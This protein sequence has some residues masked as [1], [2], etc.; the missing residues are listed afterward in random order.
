MVISS[1]AWD[2]FIPSQNKKEETFNANYKLLPLNCLM[3]LKDQRHL[4]YCLPMHMHLLSK[5]NTIMERK[6]YGKITINY[7]HLIVWRLWKASVIYL[8]P[9]QMHLLFT[10]NI[11]KKRKVYGQIISGSDLCCIIDEVINYT[12]LCIVWSCLETTTPIH[13]PL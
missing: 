7:Y 13:H 5:I 1:I 10:I 4:S 3:T 8:I 11:I 2:E 6:V 12:N 9:M